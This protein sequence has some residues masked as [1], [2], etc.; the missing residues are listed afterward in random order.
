MKITAVD[1][2]IYKRDQHYRL[3]GLEETPGLIA[4]TDYFFEPNW[5]QAY[6]RRVESCLIRVSTDV[7]LNGWGE[8]QAPLLPE[9]P[10]SIIR[11]LA[12]PHLIGQNPLERARLIDELYHMNYVRGHGSGFMM[13]AIAAV[14]LALWDLAGHHYSASVAQLL[15]G[16]MRR[17][18][19]GYVSGLRQPTLEEQCE[20]A[21]RYMDEGF[22]GIK[23]FV[24]QGYEGDAE[25]IRAVRR[26]AGPGAR[27]FC[28]FLWRYRV[29]EAIRLCR[30]LEDEGYEWVEAPIAPE[31]LSGHRR[32]VQSLDLAMAIGEALRTPYE[33]LPW[34]EKGALTVVQPD[35]GRS[36]LTA[37]L[38][39]A[40]LAEAHR[41]PVA[42]HVGVSSGVAMA[43]TWQLAAAIPNFL[44]Q[45]VQV[46]VLN[47]V[48]SMLTTP[49]EV[50]QGKPLVPDRPGLGVEVKEEAVRASAA[51][52][53]RVE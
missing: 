21:R 31:D 28:D 29:E 24:G 10:G 32:M 37:G 3:R 16:P 19:T 52:H 6:S 14:D 18:L 50:C 45:E 4:G 49:L 42:P 2:F 53:W 30:V 34:F 22:A 9:T 8:A 15:G 26:A 41:V 40:A 44:I 1:I 39:I 11:R 43:A 5:R 20:A 23:L 17:E 38:K 12:G 35:V 13:D 46:E 51:G 27:L 7:G 25:T 48:N 33:F 47:G 36:G